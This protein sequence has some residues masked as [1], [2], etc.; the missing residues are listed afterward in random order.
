MPIIRMHT[1]EDTTPTITKQGDIMT[2]KLDKDAVV[3]N[4]NKHHDRYKVSRYTYGDAFC[5]DKTFSES[6]IDGNARCIRSDEYSNLTYIIK[7]PNDTVEVMSDNF[8]HP[9][10]RHN[11]KECMIINRDGEMKKIHD[12]TY[13]DVKKYEDKKNPTEIINNSTSPDNK[14]EPTTIQ[15]SN[16]NSLDTCKGTIV[17]NDIE[18]T[19]SLCDLIELRSSLIKAIVNESSHFIFKTKISIEAS[20]KEMCILREEVNETIK[21]LCKSINAPYHQ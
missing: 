12:G 5:K 18:I 14:T 1:I 6:L 15:E 17:F 7:H 11:I 16:T 19:M 8:T 10:I 13:F 2:K 4:L 21:R 20:Q 3:V 9:T